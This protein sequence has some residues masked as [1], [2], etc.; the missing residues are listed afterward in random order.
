MKQ[1]YE[2]A[3]LH[4]LCGKYTYLTSKEKEEKKHQRFLRT[5]DSNN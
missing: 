5:S 2:A 3:A 4:E 1:A